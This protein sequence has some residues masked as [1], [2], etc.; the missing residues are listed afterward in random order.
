MPDTFKLEIISPDQNIMKS[1][2][3]EVT[4][5]AFEGLMTILKDHISLKIFCRRR[6]Y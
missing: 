5:P 6:N 4:I 1:E 3:S 2:A